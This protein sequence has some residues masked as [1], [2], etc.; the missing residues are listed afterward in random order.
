MHM[1]TGTGVL[2]TNQHNAIYYGILGKLLA[3][4][5]TPDLNILDAIWILADPYDG[6]YC[7]YSAATRKDMLLA[8]VDPVALDIWSVK[9]VLIPA[10]IENLHSP[11]W[12]E[13]SAD[14]DDPDSMFRIYLDRSMYFLLNAGHEVT[15]DLNQ[16][17]AHA[18]IGEG[19]FDADGDVDLEDSD[20]FDL[21]FTGPGGGPAA[22]GCEA[23]DFDADTDVDCDDWN[24]FRQVWTAP[25]DPPDLLECG[26]SMP[27]AAPY[28][29]NRPR[30]RY[31]SFDPDKMEND[32][33]DLAFRITLT[34]LQLSSCDDSGTPDVEGWSCRTD[35]DCRTC[36]G[37]GAPCWTAPL[38]C[39]PGETCVPTGAACVN[40]QA[41][42]VGQTWWVG[43][44]SDQDNDVHLLVTE[45][46]RKVSDAWPTV[47]FVGDCEI[48]PRASYVIR[49]VQVNTGHESDEF[50][51]NTTARPGPNYWADAV[52]PLGE[53]CTGNWAECPNGDSDC[54][55]GESCIRQ[56]PPADGF[57]NFS[58]ITAAVF[59]FQQAP[60]LAVPEVMWVDIHGDG[61]GDAK[62][63]PPNYVVNFS[64][65]G[66]MVL[67][68]QGRPY[69][70]QDPGE[71][72]VRIMWP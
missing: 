32:G 37:T 50:V 34:S 43:P 6:P 61:G 49:A 3:D 14:P 25:G 68:F 29:H 56:W 17:D 35:D 4:V 36:S 20:Q 67:A 1:G 31:I 41:N 18:W 26:P 64:D 13:P 62:V 63:D 48:V 7:S 23:G 53:Y 54:P 59:A 42:S 66:F 44:A 71:C 11:P 9:N 2:G 10:F 57:T 12:P 30:N 60:G 47:L 33:V 24:Q 27:L 69:P 15:N 21:C 5:R 22:P 45:P 52:G 72:P 8:S 65:I 46:Y 70:F 39:P 19:D 51:V 38:H 16:I 55:S 28:P 58:D 40:D